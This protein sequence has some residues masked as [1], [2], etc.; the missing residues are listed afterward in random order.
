MYSLTA[1]F[2]ASDWHPMRWIILIL[3]LILAVNWLVNN[4]P[5]SGIISV[6]L[7]YQAVTN[8]GC[9]A[10]LCRNPNTGFVIGNR[11]EFE[12]EKNKKQ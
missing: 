12:H 10:G 1:T 6:F 7:L 5:I 4:A 9:I 2:C 8:T 3:G 11:S